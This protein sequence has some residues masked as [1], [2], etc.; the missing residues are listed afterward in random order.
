MRV[1]RL[2]HIADVELLELDPLVTLVTG[3]EPAQRAQIVEALVGLVHA[4]PGGQTGLVDVHGIHLPISET[5]LRSI[6]LG[7]GEVVDNVI[8]SASFAELRLAAGVGQPDELVSEINQRIGRARQALDPESFARYDRALRTM[9]DLKLALELHTDLTAARRRL[10]SHFESEPTRVAELIG[11]VEVL[12]PTGPDAAALALAE[13][14]TAT[15]AEFVALQ[16]ALDADGRTPEHVEARIARCGELRDAAARA[17]EPQPVPETI[18]DDLDEL[19]EQMVELVASRARKLNWN[20]DRQLDELQD[21]MEDL[22][23]EVGQPTY[24]AWSMNRHRTVRPPVL[25]AALVEAEATLAAAEQDWENLAEELEATGLFSRMAELEDRAVDFL[26]PD[27]D[28]DRDIGCQLE[29]VAAPPEG[30]E[31]AALGHLADLVDAPSE[32]AEDADT[33]ILLGQQLIAD[34]EER[35]ETLRE[36]VDTYA[37][38]V[39]GLSAIE[40]D[41]HARLSAELAAARIRMQGHQEAVEQIEQ[42]QNERRHL[43]DGVP[44]PYTTGDLDPRAVQWHILRTVSALKSMTTVGSLPLVLD[45]PFEDFDESVI[46]SVLDQLSGL[47]DEFQIVVL[48]SNPIVEHWARSLGPTAT[49]IE[50]GSS[51]SLV[52]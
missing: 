41:D 34:W 46:H 13:E 50:L 2:D 12:P 38:S 8:T 16:K 32:H 1:A 11:E 42:L 36:R 33:L 15:T 7:T 30:P 25:V 37:A 31:F 26:G 5:G 51:I 40:S 9:E 49:V 17:A 35:A 43:L 4:A 44:L 47:A 29:E 14:W 22:L 52:N 27:L 28:P 6:G 18:A 48:S 3:A 10:S 23:D 24:A 39:E 21:R 45:E 20:H 19:H